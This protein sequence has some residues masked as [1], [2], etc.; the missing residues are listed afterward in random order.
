[1]AVRGM[2]AASSKAAS[3]AGSTTPSSTAAGSNAGNGGGN[4]GAQ[5]GITS[6]SSSPTT[7]N[8][9]DV[10]PA[11]TGR[12][13]AQ[14]VVAPGDDALDAFRRGGARQACAQSAAASWRASPV[15]AAVDV[16]AY[17]QLVAGHGI[18]DILAEAGRLLSD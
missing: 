2:A 3:N 4:K 12:K 13:L 7:N 17:R 16:A 5:N 8:S 14:I 11:A 1:M 15:P 9:P 6:S 10:A 18:V